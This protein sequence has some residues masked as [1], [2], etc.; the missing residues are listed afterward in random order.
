MWIKTNLHKIKVSKNLK[1]GSFQKTVPKRVSVICGIIHYLKLLYTDKK[2][3]IEL[4]F[5]HLPRKSFSSVYRWRKLQPTLNSSQGCKAH[6]QPE[7]RSKR[8]DGILEWCRVP[9]LQ[10]VRISICTIYGRHLT[11]P[12][13]KCLCRKKKKRKLLRQHSLET[14]FSPKWL[15]YVNVVYISIC[16][17]WKKKYII[18]CTTHS[19]DF[20][21]NEY[22]TVLLMGLAWWCMDDMSQIFKILEIIY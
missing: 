6:H 1:I 8:Q 13:N 21:H 5:H 16:L 19:P 10:A 17:S 18:I 7:S 3:T 22:I 20:F 9:V 15:N 11:R 4:N 14:P 12:W 2:I